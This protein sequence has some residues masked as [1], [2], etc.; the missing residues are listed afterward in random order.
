M[1][2]LFSQTLAV[3]VHDSRRGATASFA[4]AHFWFIFSIWSSPSDWPEMQTS[5]PYTWQFSQVSKLVFFS[6]VVVCFLS[7]CCH[8]GEFSSWTLC[9]CGA[10]ST[11]SA[12]PSGDQYLCEIFYIFCSAVSQ[13]VC[14][15][16]CFFS[17]VLGADKSDKIPIVRTS[18]YPW[19]RMTSLWFFLKVLEYCFLVKRTEITIFP[20]HLHKLFAVIL[21][22]RCSLKGYNHSNK[23]H[24]KTWP[25][26]ARGRQPQHNA[27]VWRSAVV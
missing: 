12:G 3:S 16:L 5:F 21:S 17:K 18:V 19:R 22:L 24:M 15:S 10:R 23:F 1:D 20:I 7:S 11:P 27:I 13:C 14:F 4:P 25:M 2:A 9:V 6:V 26:L 8:C